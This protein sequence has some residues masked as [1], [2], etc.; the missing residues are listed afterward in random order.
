MNTQCNLHCRFREEQ[1]FN[2]WWLYLMVGT[3]AVI[4]TI[5][6]GYGMFTQ[7][8]QG[9]S[10]GNRPMPNAALAVMGPMVILLS[11]GLVFLV[12]WMSLLVEVRES[13]VI[14][15][16]RPFVRREIL[17]RDIRR[18]DAR[19]YRPIWEYGGWG[20][21]FSSKGMAYNVS[22]D[23]GVQL[24]LVNGKRILVGSQ[25]SEALAQAIQEGMTRGGRA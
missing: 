10:W 18:C 17:F 9:Q 14:I 24:E 11:W 22:G 12:R 23:R 21:R 1:R 4:T 15:R 16:F 5:L 25:R 7:L 8:V 19:T 3:V 20:V 2:K 13:G 6:F